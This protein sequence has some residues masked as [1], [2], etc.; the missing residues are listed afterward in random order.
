MSSD[1]VPIE[2]DKTEPKPNESKS[3]PNLKLISSSN[4]E[5]LKPRKVS[6]LD[7]DDMDQEPMQVKDKSMTDLLEQI[8]KE[9]D[10]GDIIDK[11]F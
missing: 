9:K 4:I 2:D 10:L 6:D 1:Q 5:S 3:H 7:A 11:Q 8:Q